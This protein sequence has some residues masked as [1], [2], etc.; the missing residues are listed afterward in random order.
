[1]AFYELL[2]VLFAE[3]EGGG[4]GFSSMLPPMIAIGVIFYFIM[5]RGGRIDRKKRQDSLDALKKNDRVVTIGGIIGT[6]AGTSQD[7]KEV[8]LKIDDNAKMKVLRS[9]IQGPLREDTT[10]T[11]PDKSTEAIT[12][13]ESL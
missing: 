4:G 7:G 8:T 5:V 2:P 6:I 11:V 12:T 10:A 9:A 1:M 13:N 3:G